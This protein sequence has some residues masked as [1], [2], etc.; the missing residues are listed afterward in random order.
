MTRIGLV[1]SD[2]NYDITSLMHKKAEEQSEL[3]GFE[4]E[5]IRVPGVFDMPLAVKALL[6]KK[7]IDGVALIGAVIKGETKH[8][9][10]VINQSIR[11]IVDMS[12]EYEKPV[13]IGI[14]GPGAEHDQA[15]ARIEEYSSRAV[16]SLAKLL[17]ALKKD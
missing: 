5:S 17:K 6:K 12:T 8:D 7:N 14:I 9:E 4:H 3:L 16:E 11:K 13:T 15:V 2:F 10:L 1:V